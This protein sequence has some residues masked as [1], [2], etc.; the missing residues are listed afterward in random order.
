M[1]LVLAEAVKST[2]AVTVSKIYSELSDF[3]LLL[4]SFADETNFVI[5]I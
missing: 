2:N 5:A 3:L 4:L 1:I